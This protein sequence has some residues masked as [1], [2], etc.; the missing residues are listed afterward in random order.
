MKNRLNQLIGLM[1]EYEIDVLLLQNT[2]EY[3]CEYVH[4]NKQRIRWLCGFSGSNATLIISR[5]G[6]QNFFTDGRYTLQAT[7]ELDCSYYQIHNVCELTPWQWC[8]ENCLSHTVVAYESALFTLSQIRKYEDCGIFLKPIDQILIDKLW[9]RDFAI[10]HDIVQHSL[11]YSGV[12]SYTKSCEVAK[13]LSDKDAALI[14]NTDVISWMLN[15]RNKKF[16]YNPSVLSRAILYKD[17]R[18]DLFIDDVY[19]V[20]VKYEHLNICSL[21]NLFNV[22]KSV[23]SVVVDASTIPMSIFLSLQQQDVLVNDADFCL[24]MKARKND[25]EIQGAINAHVRDGISIVNLL[26]WLNMQ[27]DNN[28][29]ITELDVESKLLDFR[30]QQSLFQGE[31]FSTISGFQENGA[32]IHY[33]ANNDT[34]KLICKNGLYLLDSGGQYLDGTTDVTRTVAIGEPTS[35]QITNF[36]LVLK[37]HIAL[38]MAVFPLGT[39]GGMLDIL[40]RQYLWKSGLDYQHGTGHGVGSFLSVHEGPCAISYKNDVVL[41]PNMVLSNEPGYYKNGEYG[42]RIENL[43]YVEEY[44][45]GFL[46]FKQLTCVP[47]DL[48]LIDVDM[49]NHEEI[50]YI[51]QYHNFVYNTIAPHVSEEVKHWLC[52]ACQSLKGK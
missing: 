26:Y 35:E 24:L 17:G 49:L 52:H 51:D 40:A 46:R 45:N 32:V 34:N 43:M 4:I 18:V 14:T 37:G 10:E 28:Q 1:E 44:M 19:S 48:R 3:Q 23:K 27:L 39:T 31:S 42:I 7:R 36:T 47:I 6:K 12:E 5:E 50:N 16:L 41:Q 11:E 25:V 2:D 9:I 15:I 30:K 20:N 33:R 38:A 13:Y 29:K 8:V 21:N 22:L